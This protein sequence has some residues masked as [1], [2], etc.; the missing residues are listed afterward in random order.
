MGRG[1]GT[2]RAVRRGLP[3]GQGTYTEISPSALT[4]P[5]RKRPPAPWLQSLARSRGLGGAADG[6]EAPAPPAKAPDGAP[7]VGR[8]LAQAL[9]PGSAPSR[10]APA[11]IRA[12]E[13][14]RA[15][16]QPQWKLTSSGRRVQKCWTL[17]SPPLRKELEGRIGSQGH[18][19]RARAGRGAEG[20]G[21][22]LPPGPK[23]LSLSSF[24]TSRNTQPPEASAAPGRPEGAQQWREKSVALLVTEIWGR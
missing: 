1:E 7:R 19:D 24:G 23:A 10:P 20:A 22:G 16:P 5:D 3:G 2:S 8:G 6:R 9:P 12:E 17:L 15:S 14:L 11:C 18:T 21:L 4:V 13:R